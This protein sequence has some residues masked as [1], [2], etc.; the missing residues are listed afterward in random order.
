MGYISLNHLVKLKKYFKHSI[1]IIVL[2]SVLIPSIISYNTIINESIT[3]SKEPLKQAIDYL[4][5]NSLPNQT[6]VSN[7]WVYFGYHNNLKAFSIW[8]NNIDMLL[9]SHNFDYLI[10][11]NYLDHPFENLNAV[12]DS[13]SNY[14]P[15]H[16]V[17]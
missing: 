13:L 14:N 7:A 3:T 15:P 8:T 6:I 1:L 4:E 2:I 9:E 10:F 12:E 17:P 5:N 16:C 11:V